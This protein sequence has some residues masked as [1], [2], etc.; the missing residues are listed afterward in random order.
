G[1]YGLARGADRSKAG[2]RRHG[3]TASASAAATPSASSR[4]LACSRWRKRPLADRAVLAHWPPAPF[5]A[6]PWVLVTPQS[7]AAD[8]GAGGALQP[9]TRP[10]SRAARARR[11]AST[12]APAAAG[13][14]V[15]S[16]RRASPLASGERLVWSCSATVAGASAARPTW[17]AWKA[18]PS[19]WAGS[20]S[21]GVPSLEHS[22]LARQPEE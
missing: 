5:I 17:S 18:E 22:K 21:A 9:R 3:G 19:E 15:P 11:A 2:K 14:R 10:P 13:A 12:S 4:P 16:D 7:A 6:R 8:G 1:W 20:L